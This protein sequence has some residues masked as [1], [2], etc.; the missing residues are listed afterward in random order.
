MF[1]SMKLAVEDMASLLAR[2][3]GIS[4][5]DAHLFCMLV[6]SVRAGGTLA[7]R[8]WVDNCLIGLSVPKAIR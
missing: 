5:K 4:E 6:G 7:K 2:I 8:D 1:E 3:H